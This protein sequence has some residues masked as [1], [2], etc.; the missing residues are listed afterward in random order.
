MRSSP[1]I[2]LVLLIAVAALCAG[3]SKHLGPTAERATEATLSST[4]ITEIRCRDASGRTWVLDA[5]AVGTV[6]TLGRD[7]RPIV[8]PRAIFPLTQ[9]YV[10]GVPPRDT[11]PAFSVAHWRWRLVRPKSGPADSTPGAGLDALRYADPSPVAE[12]GLGCPARADTQTLVPGL[13]VITV[14]VPEQAGGGTKRLVCLANFFPDTWWAGPD[15]ALWPL[16]SDG[17]GS[18]AVDVTDWSLFT[19][20]PAWPP[21]GRAYFGP[22]SF[23]FLPSMRR[24]L[25]GGNGRGTF[26]EIYGNRIFA[27][28]EG[29]TV[30]Q[31]SWIVLVNGGYDRDSKYLPRVDPADPALPAG[32]AADPVRYAVLQTLGYMGSPIGFRSVVPER[33]TPAGLKMV[34]AST[35][36]YPVYEPASVFRA[37]HLAGY[38]R[39][40]AAGKGYALARAQDADGGL[41]VRLGDAVALAD[42]V[43]AGGGTSADR[44][45]RRKVVTFYVDKAPALV[46]NDAAFLPVEGQ[47]LPAPAGSCTWT[48]RLIGMDADPT[49]SDASYPSAGGPASSTTLRFKITLYGKSLAGSDTSWTYAVPGGTSYPVGAYGVAARVFTFRPGGETGNPFATGDVTVSIE[50]CDC[51]SCESV[52]GQGRCVQG[53]DPVTRQVL[54][55]QNVITVHFTRPE[56]C[57]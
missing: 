49:S 32:Y 35:G 20:A 5:W 7:A 50:I 33:L 52:P 31:N 37:P 27:R 12:A 23:R 13:N 22:D 53:I 41:D 10:P 4:G 29:D 55:P 48:F 3:C 9:E 25:R 36:I 54:N 44:I 21:D 28:A 6:V 30:H 45:A 38:W 39:M 15:P 43:D 34:P 2:P 42:L 14:N 19:T 8:R 40:Y 24:P 51:A 11:V 47:S 18:R 57:P 16:A 56:G 26:Y 17:S 1:T 46:R